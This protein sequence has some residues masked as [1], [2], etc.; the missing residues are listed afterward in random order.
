M[1]R[2][3]ESHLFLMN[4]IFNFPILFLAD[5]NFLV[6]DASQYKKK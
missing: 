6:H 1:Q 5:K 4:Q 3:I 2:V